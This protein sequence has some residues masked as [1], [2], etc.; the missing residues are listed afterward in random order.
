MHIRNPVE[1]FFGQFAE[2][3][4]KVGDAAPEDYWPAA[5]AQ[6]SPRVNRIAAADLNHALRRGWEDF[7]AAR[8]DL[9]MFCIIYPIL[10]LFL[11]AEEGWGHALALLFPTAAGFALLGPLF[12]VGLYEMSRQRELTGKTSWPDT[13][14][15]LH[16]PSIGAITGL[17][18]L[19]IAIFFAWLAA[20]WGIFDLTL[21]PKAPAALG[22]FCAEVFTTPA[23]WAMIVLGIAVGAIF[24]IGVLT[25]SVVSFPLLLD[26]P[27]GTKEAVATSVQAVRRNPK[28][29][30]LWGLIVAAGLILG[31]L[32]CFIGL[33][34]VLPVLG[35]ATWHL[36]R[37]IVI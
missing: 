25:I 29:L 22:A 24:A 21:G 20:A 2:A 27:V 5:R 19:L 1:W 4:A 34:I 31:A 9:V 14:R 32:P 8:T 16:A 7:G 15:V 28:T 13:F 23:G 36:Y 17:G 11:W 18:L 12:A 3:P 26:R 10:G 35:H 6:R 30:A 33:I 37:R